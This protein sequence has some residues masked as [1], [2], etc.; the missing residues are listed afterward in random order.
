MRLKISLVLGILVFS[1]VQLYA[2]IGKYN[3]KREL[4]GV[5]EDWHSVMIQ[6]EMY[7][8]LS[9]NLSDIR[10]Y[11][12]TASKDTIEAPYI[13]KKNEPKTIH[14]KVDFEILNTARTVNGTFVTYKVPIDQMINQI[15]LDFDQT[16]FDTRLSVEGSQDLKSWFTI[17]DDYRVLSINNELTS[18]SFT[19]V[20]F[21]NSK[22]QYYRILV[23][24]DDVPKIAGAQ[25]NFKETK[26]GDYNVYRNKSLEIKEEKE[27]KTTVIDIAL[28]TPVPV[29]KVKIKVN[30]TFDYYRPV[31]LE[32]ISDSTKIENGW[33]YRY[34]KL[35]SGVINSIE[36][37]EF[38]FRSEIGQRLRITISNYDNQ[39][40]DIQAVEILGVS[41]ELIA[42]FTTPATY[43]LTYGNKSSNIPSYD[44]KYMTEKIPIDL[45]SLGLGEEKSIPKI[46]EKKVEPLFTN[47]AWL[48]GIML[49]IILILGSFTL[50]MMKKK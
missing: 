1:C 5:S 30:N 22:Y 27:N 3:Y 18:Y 35:T 39:P 26:T 14:K 21:S 12:I 29:N 24:G 32:Y 46:S 25:I 33:R 23:K 44:L 8:N 13:L 48:W 49:V 2:Q 11:G 50:M 17:T 41:H 16:N 10:I 38:D 15:R 40:L 7:A 9:S 28:D 45:K 37:N 19:T 6:D 4:L 34:G 36:E 20:K 31:R 47:K 42:R 43:Y